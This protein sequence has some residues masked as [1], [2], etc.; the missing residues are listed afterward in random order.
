L[1][2][3][4]SA[5]NPA[6]SQ[7]AQ[8]ARLFW[9]FFATCVVAYV[10]VLVCL[11]IAVMRRRRNAVADVSEER[12]ASHHRAVSTAA[13][14]SI[15]GLLALLVVSIS[16]GASVG[17][18]GRGR[19]DQ[20]EIEI[21]GHQWWWEVKYPDALSPYQQIVDA[22]EIHIPVHTPILLRLDTRDVIHSLWIPNL[23]G[24]RDLIPGRVNKFWI[25]ADEPGLYRGQCA[26]F[27]GLQ[28]AH[29]SLSVIAESAE[30][31]ARWKTNVSAGAPAPQT[32]AQLRGQQVFLR[33]PCGKCHNIVGTDASGTIG[34]DLTHFRSRPTLAAGT[35]LNTRGNLAGWV[36]NAPAL[37]P[38][39]EM[40]PNDLSGEELQD[41]LA[42]LETLK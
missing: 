14:V 16:V 18:F 13:A 2:P 38:G 35:L 31:F 27:C 37:K 41:L 8:L 22:N 32:A 6:G 7:A 42:Y 15:L 19:A 21:T 40:P 12:E 24:K 25:E 29:M 1:T 36:V 30:D 5:L 39:T 34:P 17:T 26:E 4:Q 10:L 23:H 3:F 9:I 11:F 33:A 28:H 20:L